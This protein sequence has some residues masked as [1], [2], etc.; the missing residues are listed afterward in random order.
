M[1]R[2]WRL[3]MLVQYGSGRSIKRRAIAKRNVLIF[4]GNSCLQS[5]N[6]CSLQHSMRG[7]ESRS[8]KQTKKLT[9]TPARTIDSSAPII[10]SIP[11]FSLL[12]SFQLLTNCLLFF[13][14]HTHHSVNCCTTIRFMTLFINE[15]QMQPIF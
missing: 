7:R 10:V 15:M 9:P 2:M 3:C 12:L 11:V 13:I 5:F 4:F 8:D 1:W 6:P 14:L